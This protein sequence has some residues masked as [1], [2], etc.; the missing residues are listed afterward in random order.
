MSRQGLLPRVPWRHPGAP[1]SPGPGHCECAR[2]DTVA[3]FGHGTVTAENQT[4]VRVIRACAVTD[5]STETARNCD[6]SS[7]RPVETD[8]DEPR[9]AGQLERKSQRP[10]CWDGGGNMGGIVTPA[11]QPQFSVMAVK[12][13]KCGPVAEAQRRR[14]DTRIRVTSPS[15]RF[16]PP[17]SATS[18]GRVSEMPAS[19]A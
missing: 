1:A 4:R 9:S 11:S 16:L 13:S 14:R 12:Q 10:P 2:Y 8:S 15:R 5:T 3:L 18:T 19:C 17:A 7:V 6:M